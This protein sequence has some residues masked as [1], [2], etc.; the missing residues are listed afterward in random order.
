MSLP[1]EIE[2][3]LLEEG[4]SVEEVAQLEMCECGEWVAMFPE[5]TYLENGN[6]EKYLVCNECWSV[7]KVEY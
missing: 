1:I 3:F 7:N 2:K 4:Y 6:K 5:T